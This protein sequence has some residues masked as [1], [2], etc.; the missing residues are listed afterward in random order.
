MFHKLPSEVLN[1]NFE[2]TIDKINFDYQVVNEYLKRI[3]VNK[4][5]EEAIKEWVKR[6]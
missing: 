2:T 3:D 5:K 4:Q 6:R 1:V